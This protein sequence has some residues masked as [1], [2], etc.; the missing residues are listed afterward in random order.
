MFAQELAPE[1]VVVRMKLPATSVL[2]LY[3]TWL[4]TKGAFVVPR[5]VAAQIELL[6]G[7]PVVDADSLLRSAQHSPPNIHCSECHEE[8]LGSEAFFA[9]SARVA[10]ASSALS[11]SP[12]KPLKGGPSASSTKVLKSAI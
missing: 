6:R 3:R 2:A 7:S 12:P 1:V 11:S 9:D 8:F 10:S 4:A 5:Q